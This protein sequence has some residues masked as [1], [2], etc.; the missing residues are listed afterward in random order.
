MDMYASL[1]A[2]APCL[3]C[4][5]LSPPPPGPQAETEQMVRYGVKLGEISWI[6]LTKWFVG[7]VNNVVSYHVRV[8]FVLYR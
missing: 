5:S 7:V 3:T 2:H 1:D 6:A 4:A 8:K